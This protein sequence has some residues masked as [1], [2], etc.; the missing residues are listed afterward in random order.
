MRSLFA[1]PT[2]RDELF[3]RARAGGLGYGDVKKDLLDRLL[4]FFAPMR[5]RRSELEKRLDDVE[6]VL[7]DGA[8]RAR[9]IG[10]PVLEQARQVAGVGSGS[11]K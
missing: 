6:D 9:K 7:A 1:E 10:I 5:E 2:E 8:E 11:G 4:K 3:E